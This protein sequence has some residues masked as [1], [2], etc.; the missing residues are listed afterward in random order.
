MADLK[1]NCIIVIF[2][3]FVAVSKEFLLIFWTQVIIIYEDTEHHF[4]Y[5]VPW[6]SDDRVG[7]SKRTELAAN[8]K[9]WQNLDILCATAPFHGD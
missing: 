8:Y 2:Y 5:V 4:P 3:S 6:L 1:Q 9:L 7:V